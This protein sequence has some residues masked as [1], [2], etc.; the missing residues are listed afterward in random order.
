MMARE[1]FFQLKLEAI[2]PV[3]EA[4][5]CSRWQSCTGEI[6]GVSKAVT[7]LPGKRVKNYRAAWDKAEG[8]SSS[9][10]K[11]LE[12]HQGFARTGVTVGATHTVKA[13]L[14]S[15]GEEKLGLEETVAQTI[16]SAWRGRDQ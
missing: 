13:C 15:L 7:N 10:S 8:S 2:G 4:G 9:I 5:G 11:C 6:L 14:E 16:L 1:N 3:S 12:S